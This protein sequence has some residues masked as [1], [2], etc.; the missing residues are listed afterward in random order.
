VQNS[1]TLEEMEHKGC[2]KPHQNAEHFFF[3]EIRTLVRERMRGLQT[4][5]HPTQRISLLDSVYSKLFAQTS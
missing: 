2:M 1:E 5:R 3:N 4:W